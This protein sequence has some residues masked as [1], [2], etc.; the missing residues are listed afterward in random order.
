[1]GGD[2][3]L[4]SYLSSCQVTPGNLREHQH[5]L[6]TGVDRAPSGHEHVHF[7]A[8]EEPCTVS[9]HLV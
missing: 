2:H 8:K 5:Q 3:K 9:Q 6:G 7:N 4:G 1:M